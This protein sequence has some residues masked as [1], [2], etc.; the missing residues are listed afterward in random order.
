MN[1]EWTYL[2]E[3]GV[4]SS[5]PNSYDTHNKSFRIIYNE[6]LDISGFDYSTNFDLFQRNRTREETFSLKNKNYTLKFTTYGKNITLKAADR[7]YLFPLESL[8]F[9]LFNE[10]NNMQRDIELLPADLTLFDDKNSGDVKLI[11]DNL[12]VE[13]ENNEHKIIRVSGYILLKE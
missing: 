11:M 10:H 4:V 12:I 6:P 7:E 1:E 9:N 5:N 13:K 2:E 3:M 8:A